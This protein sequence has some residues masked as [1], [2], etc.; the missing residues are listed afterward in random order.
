MIKNNQNYKTEHHHC[1]ECH[2]NK[3][4]FIGNGQLFFIFRFLQWYNTTK[5]LTII[6]NCIKLCINNYW[7]DVEK[8]MLCYIMLWLCISKTTLC[9]FKLKI[10]KVVVTILFIIYI[11]DLNSNLKYWLILI[12]DIGLHYWICLFYST[13]RHYTLSIYCVHTKNNLNNTMLSIVNLYLLCI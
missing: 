8:F 3:Q 7:N 13:P 4:W 6:T 5:L 11:V 10:L 1:I 12:I 9:K 2:V